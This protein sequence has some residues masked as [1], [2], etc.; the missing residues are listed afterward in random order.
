[1]SLL[2]NVADPKDLKKLNKNE[3]NEVTR[4]I[5]ERI[6]SVAK[7]NGGHLSSNLG[8]IETTVA[9]HYVFDFSKD[10]IVWDVG[11]QCYAHKILTGRNASFDKIREEGGISGFCDKDE[12]EYDVFSSGHAGDSVALGLGLCKARDLL[13]ED[14]AVVVVVGDGSFI[15]GLNLEAITSTDYKPKNFIVI[16]NDNG[17]SISKNRNGLYKLISKSTIKKGYINSKKA[18]KKVFGNSFVTKG[19]VKFR[20]FLKRVF[21][22]NYYLEKFGFKYVGNVNGNDLPS[23]IKILKN[24]KTGAKNNSVLLHVVTKKGKG[25]DAA[26][27][28]SD[29]Y[30]GVGKELSI[31]GTPYSDRIGKTII[32]CIEKDKKVV[33]ITAGMKDGTGLD[34]VEKAFPE[35]FIDVGIAEEFAVTYAAG[36]A[37]GG[38]KP[39]VAIY[40]TFLQRAYDEIMQDVCLQNLPVTFCL[41]RAG[42]VGADGKTHQGVFDISYLSGLPNMTILSPTDP[43]ETEQALK[44]ALSLDSP[45]AIRYPNDKNAMKLT[46][47]GFRSGEWET[48][49]GGLTRERKKVLILAVGPRTLK[50]ALEAANDVC[51]VRVAAVKRVK[52]LDE[53]FLS[54]ANEETIITLEENVLSGGFGS[55]VLNYYA[56][57]KIRKNVR[58]LAIKD[59]FVDYASVESQLT[60]NGLSVENVRNIIRENI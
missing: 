36:L 60:K 43:D 20:G 10:K 50:I 4:E 19:L 54:S 45:C 38:M 27:E 30:H 3:L 29:L 11:H 39:V 48:V 14:Y 21:N 49:S 58:I 56:N 41:D 23:M 35:N 47:E 17:M 34:A 33:A 44:Y 9:L 46:T 24:V 12:S 31:G 28:R 16:L 1:M 59:E 8:I 52:P 2:E 53:A 42:L 7:S 25:L 5:R 37:K 15:N 51:G 57:K 26:E 32:E 22:K 18:I 6:I 40:S 13:G 55:A